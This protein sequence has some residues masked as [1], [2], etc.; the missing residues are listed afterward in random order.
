MI[1]IAHP[2]LPLCA[3]GLASCVPWTIRPLN[4]QSSSAVDKAASPAA[5]VDAIWN[6]KLVPALRTAAVDARELLTTL[7]ANREQA[8]ARYG[9]RPAP[10]P[11]YWIVKGEG[12]VTSADTHSR[13]GLLLVDIAPYDRKPDLSIQTGPILQG[14]ALRDATGLI[15]FSDF[16]NQLQ[17][18]DVGN[19]LNKRVLQSVL[20]SLQ[21]AALL[22]RRLSFLGALDAG[23]PSDPPLRAL[24]P[25]ELTPEAP[26]P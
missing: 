23:P 1:R 15:P 3:L 4:P 19:E 14:T 6:P 8:L 7:A 11:T 10:G 21:P 24:L 5:Y 22:G 18:A 26:R 25:V 2:A 12:V 17:Y 16:T 20:A 9:H 13:R